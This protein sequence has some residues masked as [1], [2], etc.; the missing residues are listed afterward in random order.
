MF[1]PGMDVLAPWAGEPCAYPAVVV[2]LHGD[3]A[4]V[5]YWEGD[6]AMVPVTSLRPAT[7][8]PGE[9]VQVNWK[10]QGQ[11]WPA[12]IIGRVGGAV[13]V[14]YESDGSTDWTTWAKCRVPV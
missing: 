4:L 7:Y 14:Q 2:Q 3:T 10:N 1:Q 13:Q 11:Y 6:A 8:A 5:A 9:R 12:V